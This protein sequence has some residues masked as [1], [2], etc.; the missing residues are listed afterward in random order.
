M[1]GILSYVF[2]VARGAV[3]MSI[4][5]T[6]LVLGVIVAVLP[7]DEAQ[8]AR[9]FQQVSAGAHWAVTF[10]DRNGAL[11]TAAGEAWTGFVK[12]AEFGARLP[13]MS[14]RSSCRRPRSA[15]GSG[16]GRAR[17]ARR[18]RHPEPRRP[19]TRWRGATA[20]APDV[21]GVAAVGGHGAALVIQGRVPPAARAYK[22]VA[23]WAGSSA[24]EHVTF[25]HGVEG[26]IPP[27]SPIN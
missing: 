25:N 22:P 8:Q 13:T 2:R 14:C 15:R 20:A 19:A 27:G 16:R 11:C 18:A 21:G 6:A 17:P 26:S 5:R 3:L 9:L 24:V 10:C 4:V 1:V 7:T 12:K 23:S